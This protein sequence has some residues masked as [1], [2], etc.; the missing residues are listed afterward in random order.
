MKKQKNVHFNLF[1][2]LL[3]ITAV[4]FASFTSNVKG[5]TSDD[6]VGTVTG[7]NTISVGDTATYQLAGSS[8]NPNRTYGYT[9]FSVPKS[10]YYYFFINTSNNIPVDFEV[11][12]S[13]YPCSTSNFENNCKRAYLS[14]G[15]TYYIKLSLQ[16][17]GSEQVTVTLRQFTSD[18]SLNSN[19]TT[20]CVGSKFS[21]TAATTPAGNPV[22][23]SSSDSG[24]ASVDA[25]GTVTAVRSGTATITASSFDFFERSIDVKVVQ[26]DTYLNHTG[27]SLYI[28]GKFTLKP[29]GLWCNVTS[30]KFTN[31]NNKIISVQK[32]QGQNSA[33]IKAKKPGHTSVTVTIHTDQGTFTKTCNVTVMSPTLNHKQKTIYLGQTTTLKVKHGTG[34][35]KWSTSNKKVCKVKNGVVSPKKQGTSYVTAVSNG[36]KIKCKIIVKNPTLNHKDFGIALGCSEQM[37]VKRGYSLQKTAKWS[38]SNSNVSISKYGLVRGKKLGTATI[39]C[40]VNGVT[41]KCKV[42][43]HKN[44]YKYTYAYGVKLDDLDLNNWYIKT[45]KL[46]FDGSKLKAKI[47]IYNTYTDRKIK[48]FSCI[49][50]NFSGGGESVTKRFVNKK[51]NLGTYKSKSFTLTIPVNKKLHNRLDLKKDYFSYSIDGD[52]DYSCYDW[53]D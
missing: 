28:N 22:T 1:A 30:A 48:R 47:R 36:K 6:F 34:K 9:S 16:N 18:I 35:V 21:L 17:E 50:V 51:V 23:W 15:Y 4:F 53:I 40:K 24:V 26:P 29:V 38:V 25:N 11:Y 52:V 33:T 14:T 8:E 39:K 42:T 27:R 7:P 44:Q 45:Q 13:K 43:V 46:Y 3:F 37:Y 12:K 19:G 10:G 41:I 31:Y 32:N 49:T 2:I 20:L 5:Y